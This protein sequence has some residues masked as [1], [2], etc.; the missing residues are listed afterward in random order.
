MMN[1]MHLWS[2]GE[3]DN[4]QECIDVFNYGLKSG[5]LLQAGKIPVTRFHNIVS[6]LGLLKDYELIEKFIGEWYSLVE[7]R[8]LES[9]KKLA[10]AQNAFYNE[11]YDNIIPLLRGVKYENLNQ[12]IRAQVHELAGMYKSS[13]GPATIKNATYNF[14]RMLSRNKRELSPTVYKSLHAYASIIEEMI[15]YRYSNKTIHLEKYPRI[16]LRQWIEHEIKNIK[17]QN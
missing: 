16:Y 3:I 6:S 10:Q 5:I 12:K 7:G 17:K 4:Q 14:K 15:N 2:S 8:D 13:M 9:T 11:R 1:T